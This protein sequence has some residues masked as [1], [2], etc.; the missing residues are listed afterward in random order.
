MDALDKFFYAF[1]LFIS[2]VAVIFGVLVV[3]AQF[4]H[5][6]GSGIEEGIFNLCL[7]AVGR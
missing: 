5:F 2:Y 7:L 3:C 6:Y 1:S 4:W